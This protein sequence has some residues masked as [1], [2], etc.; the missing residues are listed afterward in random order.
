MNE[1]PQQPEQERRHETSAPE[2][3]AHAGVP[4]GSTGDPG[5]DAVL[6][7]LDRLEQLSVEEHLPLFEEAHEALRRALNRPAEAAGS[8]G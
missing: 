6:S 7:T 8:G 5:V 4:G 2:G 3:S 1:Q